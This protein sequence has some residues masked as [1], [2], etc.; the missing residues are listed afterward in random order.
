MGDELVLGGQIWSPWCWKGVWLRFCPGMWPHDLLVLVGLFVGGK[1]EH[2]LVF[3]A[4]LPAAAVVGVVLLVVMRGSVVI[5]HWGRRLHVINIRMLLVLLWVWL[6]E[7]LWVWLLKLL[8]VWLHVG[9]V[10]R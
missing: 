2:S 4:V 7:L 1:G 9:M 6:L 10:L 8:W 5:G 3:V